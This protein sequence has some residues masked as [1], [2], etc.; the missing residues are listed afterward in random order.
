MYQADIH[1]HPSDQFTIFGAC[2]QTLPLPRGRTVMWSIFTRSSAW[3]KYQSAAFTITISS[4]LH[5]GDAAISDF[6]DLERITVM[7]VIGDVYSLLSLTMA[8]KPTANGPFSIV[9]PFFLYFFFRITIPIPIS[10]FPGS[11]FLEPSFP[12]QQKSL[13]CCVS[14]RGCDP[15]NIQST[16]AFPS[17]VGERG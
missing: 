16:S 3:I 7:A 8:L 12:R 1:Q 2:R 17:Q 5:S 15:V 14:N 13:V 11:F 9:F 4:R 6:Q 10:F